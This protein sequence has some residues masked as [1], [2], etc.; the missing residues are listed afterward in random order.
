MGLS[1]FVFSC[2]TFSLVVMLHARTLLRRYNFFRSKIITVK[3][4]RV[5]SHNFISNSTFT[6]AR[7]SFVSSLSLCRSLSKLKLSIP[8]CL[9][10]SVSFY[11]SMCWSSCL[12]VCRPL[13]LCPC[14]FVPLILWAFAGASF[15]EINSSLALRKYTSLWQ[16]RLIFS[17]FEFEQD[18]I[19]YFWS[20]DNDRYK[21]WCSF[22]LMKLIPT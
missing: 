12:S 13:S 8:T 14:L 22:G 7:R 21:K 11:L 10:V 16:P 20:F 5:A 6:L 4:L 17:D 1:T 19:L 18:L 3:K 2:F 15:S 9:S